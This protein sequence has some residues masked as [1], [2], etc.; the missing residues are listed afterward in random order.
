VCHKRVE[1]D[2]NPDIPYGTGPNRAFGTAYH[3]GL[4]GWYQGRAQDEITAMV[5]EAFNR[6]AEHI[7][8][9][10]PDWTSANDALT[11]AGKLVLDYITGHGHDWLDDHDVVGTEVTL[12]YPL[13]DTG[14]TMRGTLDLVLANRDTGAHVIVDHKTAR[15]PWKKGKELFRN[16]NQP[17]WYTFF[18]PLVWAEAHDGEIPDVE[19]V[20]DVMTQDSKFEHRPAPVT[21]AQR[22]AVLL[23]ASQA[24]SLIEADGPY[25]PNTQSFLCSS[26]WCDHWQRCPFGAA[27]D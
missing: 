2:R 14:W 7:D 20:F 3:A 4:E 10:G 17:A 24:C 15:R 16:T 5:A 8:Q 23:K 1:F 12:F 21:D 22:E 19:F 13:G 26:Q 11:H 6:E 27:A 25:L 9:W 18:W